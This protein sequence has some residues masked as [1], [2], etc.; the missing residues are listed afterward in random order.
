MSI[1]K[2][3]NAKSVAIIGAN[4][5][6]GYGGRLLKSLINYDYEGDIFPVNQKYSELFGLTCYPS[7]SAIHKPIDLAAIVVNVKYVI[8]IVEECARN[9]VGSVLIISAGFSEID[10]EEGLKKERQ[11]AQIAHETGMRIAG[12]NCFGLANLDKKMWACSVPRI[13]KSILSSVDA[14]IV[15]QSGA[16]GFGPLLNQA[17]DQHVGFKYVVT[18]GNEADLKIHDFIEYMLDDP[19][20]KVVAALIE[21]FRDGKECIRVFEK[22]QKLGKHIVI[23]KIGETQI[24]ARAAANHTASMTGDKEVFNAI[25]KQY[26]LIKVDD[27][28]EL[29]QAVRFAQYEKQIEGNKIAVVSHSGGISGFIGDQLGKCG[30]EVPELSLDSQQKINQHLQNFGSANNPLDLTGKMKTDAINDIARIVEENESMD[31][32][33]FATQG[34]I[35]DIGKIIEIE[36]NSK[37]PVY[38]LWTGS[39]YDPALD[40]IKKSKFPIVYLPEKAAKLVAK[41][42]Y[43]NQKMKESQNISNES[44]SD[45]VIKDIAHYPTDTYLS[46]IEGKNLLASIGLPIPTHVKINSRQDFDHLQLDQAP[47]VLKI[48]SQTITHKSDIDG[49]HLNLTSK[50]DVQSA[51]LKLEQV[52][53]KYVQEIIGIFLEEMSPEGLDVII[54]VQ[55]DEQF[56]PIMML[57]LGGVY[58]ELFKLVTWRALPMQRIEINRMI[59]EIAG[60]ET[61]LSGYRNQPALDREAFIAALEQ[62]SDCVQSNKDH[63]DSLEINPLR[64]LAQGSGVKILDCLIKMKEDD[65]QNG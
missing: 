51:Y 13:D 31:A 62:I 19:K 5:K 36:E 2:M 17:K 41:L 59:A 1:D 24:G 42:A 30:M 32:F 12:P 47:Y 44:K 37:L 45:D 6:N 49:V 27:Y 8:D 57:G 18:T 39:I 60:F 7:V 14:G 46:E 15:S 58:T 55:Q 63:I 50:E 11:L 20:I 38:L 43:T 26:G 53:D 28:D 29:I 4:E 48:E 54:G 16:T 21:G 35:Q 3:L 22:A 64:I 61:I 23:L 52:Q 33:L 56:G 34:T 10:K 40:D 25:V 9:N 65:S